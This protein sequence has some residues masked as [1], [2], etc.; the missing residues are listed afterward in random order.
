MYRISMLPNNDRI[1]EIFSDDHIRELKEYGNV[2]INEENKN[3][4]PER[5][6]ELIRDADIAITSWGCPRLT[7]DILDAAPDLKIVIHAAGSVKGIVSPELWERGIRVVSSAEPLA[8]GVAETTLGLAI[9]T[10]KHVW[11]LNQSL[12]RGGWSEESYKVRELYDI[13]VGIIGASRVGRHFI[14]LL[15]NFDVD[16]LVYDPYLTG[17]KA[18]ELGV[19]KTALEDLIKRSDIVSVHAPELPSTYRMLNKERLELLKDGAILINTARGS[20]IDEEALVDVLKRKRIY[21][22]IDVTDPEPPKDD[23]PFRTLPN[24]I[25][26]PH[27]AGLATNGR[28]RIGRYVL[29]ELKRYF[30]G[31]KLDGEVVKSMLEYIA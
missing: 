12:E 23:H 9:T 21:A 28:K 5:V 31:E 2:V 7:G 11:W 8:I 30:A 19:E 26:T 6:K 25:L 10:I 1:K 13:T 20:L 3:P 27:I 17:E 22:C 18:E 16:I 29:D 24:V 4:G 15:R 14:R